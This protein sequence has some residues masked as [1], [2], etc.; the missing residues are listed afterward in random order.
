MFKISPEIIKAL[1]E[2][3]IKELNELQE[4][5]I[6]LILEGKDLLIVAPTGSGKT[7]AAVVPILHKILKDKDD[8][9]FQLLYITPLRALNRDIVRRLSRITEKI[10]LSISV[11]HGDTIEKERRKQADKPPKILL[12]TPET[13]QILF[14]GKKLK[15][16]LRN[17]KYV[18]IDEV[19][20]L[21]TSKRGTQLSIAL[22][23]LRRIA[24]FQL[25]CLSATVKD[26]KMV[27][28]FFSD[29]MYILD[30]KA[31]KKYLYSVIKP[32]ITDKDVD[33]VEKL[34]VDLE[35]ASELRKIKEIVDNHKSALIFVNT[36]QTA[37][38]L[39]LKLK[40]IM[41]VEVHHGSLSR[42]ARIESEQK[43]TN[44]ELKALICT[45]SMEL[46]IDIGHVDVV[47]QFN[48][49]REVS[50]LIQ[51]VGRSG[52]KI[53]R[54]SKGFIIAGNFDDILESWIIV[55]RAKNNLIEDEIF[56]LGCYDVLANQ[57]AAMVIE[58][59]K[60]KAKDI[61]ELVKRSYPYKGL[62]WETFDEVCRFLHEINVVYYDGDHVKPLRKTRKYFY[63][64]ISMIPDERQYRV[65][66]ITTNKYIG[67]LDESFLSTFEG[68]VFAI[69]G[70]VWRVVGVDNDL[71]KVEP[72]PREGEI[73]SWVGEE[74]PVPF[75]VAQDVGKI[76]VYIAGLIRNFG[77]EKTIEILK[78]RFNTNYEAC[79]EVVEIIGKQIEKGFSIPS[80]AV[81]TV[82]SSNNLC[83]VNA[84]FGHKV[85][86]ALG[87][88]LAW[89]LTLKKGTT[90]SVEIDPYRIKLRP[91]KAEEVKEAIFRLKKENLEELAERSLIGTK[92]LEW[93]VVNIARKFG[94]LRKDADLSKI[95]LKN[96]VAKLKD[97]PIYKEAIREIF[98][99][100]MDVNRLKEIV[101]DFGT[102]IKILTYNELS[103]ISLVSRE[104]T[105]DLLIPRKPTKL[106]LD[107]FKK[108]IEEEWCYAY[109][110]YCKC[111][112][113]TKVKDFEFKCAKCKSELV[114]CINARRSLDEYSKKDLFRIANMVK[115]YGMR[116]VYALNTYGVGPETASRILSRY[117]RNDDEFFTELLEAEKRFIRTRKFW[118]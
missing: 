102:K 108:R 4:K 5:A 113:R 60:I 103:P 97:T 25:I 118:S 58:N 69:K 75:E 84:C 8:A 41:N 50:R 55:E 98:T 67:V 77:P 7:E 45:S 80:D 109:C 9:G 114:A 27:A 100:K 116:A 82:E 44:G 89:I 79:K 38:A 90:V 24:K 34:F 10:G 92:L 106:I 49:P 64:N 16:A 110:L 32:K 37:E 94:F 78:S 51:R 111:K 87:R 61:Y 96:L 86:E 29:E 57:I 23:R 1:N 19:H 59:G 91:V 68:E 47:I 56:H 48:S 76:R 63:E 12:T 28:K 17:V 65:I 66:D 115:S 21:V 88:V 18:I 46:G 95:N 93:K 101:K 13:F 31:E 26:P 35:I 2:V 43:F 99:E 83:V 62:T 105:V 39:G 72:V 14:L 53:D 30:W 71:V 20:E 70:E 81:I 22:E 6:K 73:P 3:G 33:L 85:N 42:E 117:Y 52:H 15:K 36:R 54:I 74:I 112:I 40:K 104:H 107:A 11:R